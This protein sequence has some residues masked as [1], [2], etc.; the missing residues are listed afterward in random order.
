MALQENDAT[1]STA[2]ASAR[3]GRT[4]ADIPAC[5]PPIYGTRN[6]ETFLLLLKPDPQRSPPVAAAA[7]VIIYLLFSSTTV[8]VFRNKNY[9]S[10]PSSPHTRPVVHTTGAHDWCT[11]RL[12]RSSLR[13][14]SNN[15][16]SLTDR[17]NY[18]VSPR[19]EQWQRIHTYTRWCALHFLDDDA[20][21]GIHHNDTGPGIERTQK[22][23]SAVTG[24]S[25]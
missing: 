15:N 1:V 8:V 22:D 3:H 19:L 16:L 20:I 5:T 12:A 17:E 9:Y 7:V 2:K 6:K 24:P 4:D 13:Y 11:L 23:V 14:S 21:L 10:S 18:S 25:S